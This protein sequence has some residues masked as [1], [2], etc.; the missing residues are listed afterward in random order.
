MNNLDQSYRPQDQKWV[1]Q[2]LL[3]F[4]LGVVLFGLIAISLVIGFQIK[5]SQSIYPGVNMTGVDLSGMSTGEAETILKNQITYS[6]NGK[7]LLVDGTNTWLVSPADLGFYIDTQA[8]A[9]QALSI[10]RSKGLLLNLAEQLRTWKRGTQVLPIAI[11]DQSKSFNYLQNL[12]QTIDKPIIETNLTVE[13][14]EII[15]NS[16]QIGRK[17]NIEATLALLNGPL[18]N[19]QDA[20]IPLVVDESPPVILD[21][22]ET[23][24]LARLI[25]NQPLVLSLP[26]EFTD[27]GPWMIT[28]SELAALLTIER[29]N[30]E[31]SASY[32]IG[33][34]QIA[35]RSYLFGLAPYL[36]IEP[37]NARFIFNDDTRKLEVIEPAIIGRALNIEASLDNLIRQLLEGQHAITLTIDIL[38]PAVTDTTSG[39]ELGI[40]E[41]VHAETSYFYGS[42]TARKQNIAT[43]AK[44]FHGLLIAP[45]ET[46]S[47]ANALG[48]IS[49]ENGYA[50]ALIIYGNQTIKGVGGGVCQVSTTLFRAAFFAG[51]PITE[52]HPHAYRVGYYEMQRDGSRDPNLAGLDATVYVPIVDLKFT[53]DTPY[54][55]L[56]ETYMGSYDSLTWKFYS[57]SDGRS[58]EWET[59]G[60]TNIVKAPPDLYR[61][62][63]DLAEGEIKKVDYA[64][65]GAYVRVNRDVYKNG[66]FY[67]EDSFTT[68]YQ[69]WQAIYEYGPGT[70][71]IPTPTP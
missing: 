23:A 22:T 60:A 1:I 31:D 28:P 7:I 63:P 4:S 19:L 41:L 2:L 5:N 65:D 21:V 15:V 71:D 57:T 29:E 40:T 52:R 62:N 64:A 51:F 47:M 16:G 54:W 20:V 36:G 37:V 45:G 53:N 44:S 3:A 6:G 46:F 70:K 66:V 69:P 35:L 67:F 13:G 59:T 39:E 18:M 50:E 9:S 30:S 27:A 58:I 43:A 12:A 26:V 10:G 32:K 48:N 8:S 42:D 14:T 24:N 61:L 49:L 68:Q 11:Y 33:L 17:V 25:L 34:D 56:M 38:E 55:L